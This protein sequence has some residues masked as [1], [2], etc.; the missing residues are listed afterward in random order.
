[1]NDENRFAGISVKAKINVIH[2]DVSFGQTDQQMVQISHFITHFHTKNII[3]AAEIPFLGKTSKGFFGIGNDH[4]YDTVFRTVIGN[5]A[6]NVD[7]FF[8]ED[9]G[10][11]L[12]SAF[13]VFR[14][15]RYLF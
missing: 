2:T 9:P 15:Y 5:R 10:N 13:L 7:A 1:M 6:Q 11:C 4:S 3:G 14:K 12:K 8:L